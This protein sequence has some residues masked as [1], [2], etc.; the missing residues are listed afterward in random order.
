MGL[1]LLRVEDN[2]QKNRR[3]ATLYRISLKYLL[4]KCFEIIKLTTFFRSKGSFCFFFFFGK[5]EI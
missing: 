3:K 4:K 5:S 2:M 1:D